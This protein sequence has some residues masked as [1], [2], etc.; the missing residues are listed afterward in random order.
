MLEHHETQLAAARAVASDT[1]Q[2][3]QQLNQQVFESAAAHTAQFGTSS[4]ELTEALRKRHAELLAKL[5]A[6]NGELVSRLENRANRIQVGGKDLV[7]TQLQKQ[8]KKAESARQGEKIKRKAAKQAERERRQAEEDAR[9]DAKAAAAMEKRA[10]KGRKG[11]NKALMAALAYSSPTS[12]PADSLGHLSLE[13]LATMSDQSLQ[14][15]LDRAS[16]QSVAVQKM[17]DLMRRDSN[18]SVSPQHRLSPL[19]RPNSSLEMPQQSEASRLK[20]KASK[21]KS[22]VVELRHELYNAAERE[23]QLGEAFSY[24]EGR[25][26]ELE[27][28]ARS[29]EEELLLWRMQFAELMAAGGLADVAKGPQ[30]IWA[31]LLELDATPTCE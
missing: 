1:A 20:Q 12:E 13:E 18:S 15:E 11:A 29:R 19:S 26:I 30:S 21:Y 10:A 24:M 4:E 25:C 16:E 17:H 28:E 7:I 27:Q 6:T 2:E 3:A 5:N 9:L 23:R 22:L 14:Q 31:N 8:L